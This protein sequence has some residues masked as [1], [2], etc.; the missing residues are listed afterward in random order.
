MT[1]RLRRSLGG[2]FFS[3]AASEPVMAAAA[4]AALP[5]IKRRRVKCL[6]MMRVLPEGWCRGGS[7]NLRRL[8]RAGAG[9]EGGI[10]PMHRRGYAAALAR[11]SHQVSCCIDCGGG[12]DRGVRLRDSY[13]QGFLTREDPPMS[14]RTR[15]ALLAVLG[16]ALLAGTARADLTES[17]KQG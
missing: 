4:R 14:P 13:R 10:F 9:M 8:S 16:A 6:D 15:L 1:P 17:L 5:C 12:D 2:A 7:S 11:N 3:S